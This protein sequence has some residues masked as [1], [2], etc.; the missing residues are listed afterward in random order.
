MDGQRQLAA[1]A[2]FERAQQVLRAP[3]MP[4]DLGGDRRLVGAVEKVDLDRLRVEA[5]LRRCP[6]LETLSINR[7]DVT[8]VN[9]LVGDAGGRRLTLNVSRGLDDMS[10]QRLREAGHRVLTS[11]VYLGVLWRVAGGVEFA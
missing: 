6:A 11:G 9:A 8:G 10:S 7:V 4:A 5:L 1:G 3:R 2:R